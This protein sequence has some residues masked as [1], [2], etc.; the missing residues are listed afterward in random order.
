MTEYHIFNTRMDSYRQL[1]DGLR[2]LASVKSG[3]RQDWFVWRAIWRKN[4]AQLSELIRACRKVARTHD[5]AEQFS[6]QRYEF[7]LSGLARH[8]MEER[9]ARKEAAAAERATRLAEE[10]EL[11]KAS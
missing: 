4:Y 7:V 1:S 3:T 11:K 2:D 5:H 9:M 6:G 10:A 8:Y